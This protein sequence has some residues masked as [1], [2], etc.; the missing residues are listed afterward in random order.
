M[1]ELGGLVERV[2][3]RV[4]GRQREVELVVAALAADRGIPAADLA[5]RTTD[6]YRALFAP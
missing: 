1:G 5:A 3:G 2:L 6:N 4:V